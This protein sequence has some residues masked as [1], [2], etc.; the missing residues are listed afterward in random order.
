MIAPA[1]EGT[2]ELGMKF[3]SK[4]NRFER[5]WYFEPNEFFIMLGLPPKGYS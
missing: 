5:N 1:C 4:Y 2:Q 3:G